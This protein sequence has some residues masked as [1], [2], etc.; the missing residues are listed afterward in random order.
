MAIE[1]GSSVYWQAKRGT[2]QSGLVGHWDSMAMSSRT[3]NI[4]YDLAGNNNGTLTNGVTFERIGMGFD[5]TNDYVNG[6]NSSVLSFAPNNPFTLSV[7]ANL[8]SLPGNSI[9]ALIGKGAFNNNLEYNFYIGEASNLIRFTIAQGPNNGVYIGR[10]APAITSTSWAHYLAR[11][12]GSAS[13]AACQIYLNGLRVDNADYGFG[14]YTAMSNLG[15]IVSIGAL[16][17]GSN[18]WMNG[19]Q[20]DI[21]IYNRALSQSEITQNFNATRYR[22]GV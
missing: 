11:Y 14:S 18:F 9:F 19:R 21:R 2:V 7:W 16:N 13:N 10:Q 1:A 6:S 8:N 17:S 5:G 15:A 22:F 12:D 20:E 3:G 4:V